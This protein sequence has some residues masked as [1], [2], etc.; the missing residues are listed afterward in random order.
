MRICACDC[1][2]HT[3]RPFDTSRL[4]RSA[5]AKEAEAMDDRS[6]FTVEAMIR[7]YHVYKDIW[8]SVLDEELPCQRETGNTSDPFAVG[9]LKDGV[10]VGHVPRK[11]SSICSLFLQRRG[12]II[13]RVSGHRRF[14]E[15]LPQ[16]G[17]EIPCT[18]VFTGEAKR[19]AK[20]KDLIESAFCSIGNREAQPS[21]KRKICGKVSTCGESNQ[22]SQPWVQCNGIKLLEA[23][24]NEITHGMKL[25]DLVINMAQQLLKAQFPIVTGLQST[26]LQSEKDYHALKNNNSVQI[27]HSHGDHWIV[28]SRASSDVVKVYDSV[29]DTMDK[30]TANVILNLSGGTC[31]F[32]TVTIR[33][34]SGSRDCGL[35]AIGI[36]TALCF[37]HDP[38]TINFDQ[39]RM[40]Q[41]L[42]NCLEKELSPCFQPSNFKTL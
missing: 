21:K 6:S 24:R 2:G 9:V 14:S 16:G 18:M 41:H 13:C 27:V 10:I 29:Y 1:Q 34:Q 3:H 25:N 42:V 22:D 37:G 35:F 15:D 30:E 17:L 12:S 26:L 19:T 36:S 4:D 28:A 39:D 11:I 31:S 8:N 38:V 7:G 23:H 40:R 5:R 33:K 20:A 32:E